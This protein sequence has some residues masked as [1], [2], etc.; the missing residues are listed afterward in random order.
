MGM[1]LQKHGAWRPEVV[2]T[3]NRLHSGRQ[4]PSAHN[5][6]TVDLCNADGD[7]VTIK[8]PKVSLVK[9]TI[10][11]QVKIRL[12][13]FLAPIIPKPGDI[14]VVGNLGCSLKSFDA[15]QRETLLATLDEILIPEATTWAHNSLTLPIKT[16]PCENRE[17]VDRI[18]RLAIA[19]KSNSYL[20]TIET[21]VPI[22]EWL[23]WLQGFAQR[24]QVRAT[25]YAADKIPATFHHR[26]VALAERGL[27]RLSD[28]A[29]LPFNDL[30]RIGAAFSKEQVEA[31]Q[32]QEAR[33]ADARFELQ[34]KAVERALGPVPW[35]VREELRKIWDDLERLR[36]HV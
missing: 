4:E 1:G 28:G 17:M 20:V 16:L 10:P 23:S 21:N 6:R 9:P 29:V 25:I 19:A 35:G 15:A 8:V 36:S 12:E 32:R 5:T 11:D 31:R 30:S 33:I 13:S 22:Y 7:M 34:L 26:A 27:R 24:C 3:T 14:A 2:M 18:E